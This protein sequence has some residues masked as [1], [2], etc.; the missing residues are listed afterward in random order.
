MMLFFGDEKGRE[1]SLYSS[2]YAGASMIGMNRLSA[3]MGVSER[4]QK[5]LADFKSTR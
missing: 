5:L 2:P 3:A 4:F 1:T